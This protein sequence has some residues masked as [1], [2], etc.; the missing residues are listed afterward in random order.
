MTHIN[1]F[2]LDVEG[3]ELKILRAIPFDL[4]T[5]DLFMIKYFVPSGEAESKKRLNVYS[6]FLENLGT[7]Q[8]AHIG[9]YDIAFVRK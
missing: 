8:A 2:S 9:R 1:F 5:I 6:N 4:V 7:Y 3:A